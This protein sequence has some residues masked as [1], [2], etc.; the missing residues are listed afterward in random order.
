MNVPFCEKWR[1]KTFDDV[2]GDTSTIQSLL[3]D[4]KTMPNL[5]LV[6][7]QGT[8]KTTI[9]KIV[10][11]TLTPID[12]IR[13]NGSDS[14]GVD[15]IRDKVYN[16]MTSMS[17][18]VGKPKIIWI[19]EFDYMSPNAFA[20]LRS[21]IEQYVTNARFICTCNYMHKIPEPIQSRF[22]IFKFNKL[23]IDAMRVRVRK[24]CIDESI[25]ISDDA[26][27]NLLQKVNG[28]MRQALNTLQRLA[29][30]ETK[31]ISD[32]MITS[33][34]NITEEVFNLIIGKQWSK[35]RYELPSKYPDYNE[36]ITN[37]DEMFFQ[38]TDVTL[39]Q[40]IAINKILAKGQYEMYF[41]FDKNIAFAAI[42]SRIMEEL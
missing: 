7:P 18:N 42:T 23:D 27:T 36:L 17:T 6:G 40:K 13:I 28:D 31:T 29:A 16:Y 25:T 32:G 41:C 30:N 21:M 1:P 37:L 8:G 11:D 34:Q 9:A 2:I 33:V 15:V 4:V 5:L 26:L 12:Y 38:S 14:T 22:S 35:I 3:V 39:A 19:E 10:L 20:A 24:I